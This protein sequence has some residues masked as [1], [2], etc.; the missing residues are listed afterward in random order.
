MLKDNVEICANDFTECSSTAH[1]PVWKSWRF[2]TRPA[3]SRTCTAGQSPAVP[4]PGAHD[5]FHMSIW[6]CFL[7]TGDSK[8][9]QHCFSSG[10]LFVH[11][12]SHCILHSQFSWRT[13]Q[14][15]N[16]MRKHWMKQ[17]LKP[18]VH[19]EPCSTIWPQAL[20]IWVC[21]S[22]APWIYSAGTTGLWKKK[23]WNMSSCLHESLPMAT[24]HR[25]QIGLAPDEPSVKR[26]LWHCAVQFRRHP[27]ELIHEA[28]NMYVKKN[29]WTRLFRLN[30]Y[31]RHELT[32]WSWQ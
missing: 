17:K 32:I 8:E 11:R 21:R 29:C 31:L 25:M 1:E 27:Q 24:N 10:R 30:E 26:Q 12:L 4:C 13:L 19:T 7:N 23:T 5:N 28:N 6:S 15:N 20:L 9:L 16:D 22:R 2:L 3:L 14:K 18:L